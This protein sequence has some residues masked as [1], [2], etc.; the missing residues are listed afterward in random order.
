LSKLTNLFPTVASLMRYVGLGI[1]LLRETFDR[2]N[3]LEIG[4]S[5]MEQFTKRR[6]KDSKE[7]SN[8]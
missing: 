8:D 1:Q 2:S 3:S 6:S 5:F 7:K 4:E